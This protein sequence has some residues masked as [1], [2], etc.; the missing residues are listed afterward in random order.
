[1]FIALKSANTFIGGHLFQKISFGNDYLVLDY[2]SRAGY[3]IKDDEDNFIWVSHS[4]F[5]RYF[6]KI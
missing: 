4:A 3:K 1:M 6:K 5:K 2:S